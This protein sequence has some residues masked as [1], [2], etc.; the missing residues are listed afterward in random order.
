MEKKLNEFAWNF[1]FPVELRLRNHWKCFRS[2][3]GSL[4]YRFEWHKA[5]SKGH[6]VVEN[7]P[8]A[9]RSSTSV[10]DNN[11]EKVKKF[12]LQNRRVGIRGNRCS[13]NL[14]WIDSTNLWFIFWVWTTTPPDDDNAPL[15]SNLIVT[16]FFAS[17]SDVKL[18]IL[19][20]VDFT[21]VV[22][23]ILYLK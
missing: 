19:E 16:F 14:L 8:H 15:H 17:S 4:L 6:E 22:H 3:L 18:C 23:E 10:K 11:I 9:S 1:V 21:A 7:L 12:V 5:F 13:Q 20:K 2:V